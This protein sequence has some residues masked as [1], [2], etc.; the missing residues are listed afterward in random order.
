MA[1]LIFC[2]KLYKKIKTKIDNLTSS[3]LRYVIINDFSITLELDIKNM[4]MLML[5]S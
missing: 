1:C 2:R 5:L 3:N 4:W